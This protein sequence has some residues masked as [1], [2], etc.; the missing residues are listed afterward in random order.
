M[1]NFKH[2]LLF[3]VAVFMFVPI[4]IDAQSNEYY[5]WYKNEKK[6]LSLNS[7]KNY[8]LIE[9]GL[10]KQNL[11]ERLR[12]SISK[13]GE[14][15][16]LNLR[17]TLNLY[18]KSQSY[19]TSNWTIVSDVNQSEKLDIEEV[20]YIA[21]FFFSEDG[22][23][24]GLSHLFYVKLKKPDDILELEKLAINNGVEIVGSNRF[25]PL[26]F[27]L[28]CDRDSKG[29]AL[30]MANLFFETGIFKASQPDL[31]VTNLTQ[32]A[33]DTYFSSQWGLV[34]TGQYS[35][36]SGSD[37]QIEDA[38]DI[39]QGDSDV[40]VAVF[41]HGIELDHP[42][43][44]NMSSSSYDTENATSPS[45]IEGNHGTAVAGII[46]AEA[47]NSLGIAGVAPSSPLMSISNELT[48]G[49]NTPAEVADGFNFAWDN[50]A[51]VINNSWSHNGLSSSYID[52]AIDE[53]VTYGRGG[54]GTVIVFI[55]HNDNNS[56]IRYPSGNSDV[57]AVGAVS[58]CDERKSPSSCDGENWWGSNYGT[59][60]DVVAPGVKIYTTDRQG[61][62][63]YNTSSGTAGDYVSDFNGTSSAAPFVSGIAALIISIN[64]DLTHE[65][66]RYAIESSAEKVGGY[67]YTASAGEHS[68][69]TWN[70]EMGYGRV[71]AYQALI[72]TIEQHGATLGNEMSNVSLPLYS[73]LTLNEDIGVV[74][75]STLT[76]E[77]TGTVTI[78]SAGG[79]V[80]IGSSGVSKVPGNS[81]SDLITDG[82]DD[83]NEEETQA[84]NTFTLSNNYPNPFNPSTQISFELPQQS[85][86]V[87]EVFNLVGQKVAIL[88]DG[89]RQQGQHTVTFNAGQLSSGI[90][91]YRIQ[92]GSFVQTKRM[93][94]IK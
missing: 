28:A 14:I 60:L 42:D 40:I 27:T 86:V 88:V 41:D 12:I 20:K 89:H 35:G 5:Y 83:N 8:V 4:K 25:M 84:P 33:N 58:M 45:I 61:T 54:L 73:N 69:L 1:K 70:N 46:G 50:G 62:N 93:T 81:E 87:L 82:G 91:I 9:T 71:N 52:D 18:N 7:T 59:G 51:D 74:S 6:P 79:A 77:A 24:L 55:T 21:P 48:L 29:N 92:A 26:W 32:S 3:F 56:S 64:P 65:E 2:V 16:N 31:M 94:L 68:G 63:G 67:T 38:W 19:G 17:N 15:K 23:E 78:T 44:S 39:T 72:Y 10:E 49:V 36:T 90:Y 85:N 34:N 13:I 66:V 75:G 47:N 30:E 53:A 11:S 37:I 43:M 22:D 76:I 80:S 57:I